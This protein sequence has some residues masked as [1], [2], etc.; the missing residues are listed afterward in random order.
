MKTN[1][2]FLTLLILITLNIFVGISKA[3]MP[4]PPIV[5]IR[6]DTQN[7]VI[8]YFGNLKTEN[9]QIGYEN[10][11][12]IRHYSTMAYNLHIDFKYDLKKEDFDKYLFIFYI[13]FDPDKLEFKDF[14]DF[15]KIEGYDLKIQSN[16][17]SEPFFIISKQSYVSLHEGNLLISIGIPFNINN[18]EIISYRKELKELAPQKIG[19]DFTSGITII[20]EELITFGDFSIAESDLL[21]I[22]ISI[23]VFS[24]MSVLIGF[25]IIRTRRKK[26]QTAYP[27]A[28]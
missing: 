15:S 4:P 19:V 9:V 23:F 7:D 5:D 6:T 13:F 24:I 26:R 3:E 10:I 20:E 21:F 12:I 8:E 14:T 11:D 27:G 18:F 25:L 22:L 28:I 2:I 16:G 1:K 17:S